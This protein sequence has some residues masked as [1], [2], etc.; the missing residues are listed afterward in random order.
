MGRWNRMND[1]PPLPN[2]ILIVGGTGLIGSAIAARL[3]FEGCSVALLGRRVDPVTIP[4]VTAYVFDIRQV[5]RSDDWLEHLSGV[6]AVINC[7]GV[8]QD[9]PGES[10]AAV[11]E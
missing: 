10:T 2:R 8:L 9:S 11:H 6:D 4:R 3:G 5:T 7:A 1:T